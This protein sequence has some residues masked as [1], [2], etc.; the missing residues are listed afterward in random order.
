VDF[1][2]AEGDADAEDG[3]LTILPDPDGDENGAIQKL[4]A[5][6]DLFVSGVR[7]PDFITTE[8]EAKYLPQ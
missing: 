6:A 8:E 7:Q 3:A 5:L 2:L 4:S 1:G